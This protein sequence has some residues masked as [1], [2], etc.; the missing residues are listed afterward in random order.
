MTRPRVL[1]FADAAELARAASDRLL[2]KLV[3][4]QADAAVAELCLTGGRIANAVYARLAEVVGESGFDPGQ[5]ELWWGDERFVSSTS[6][7]RNSL[8]ALSLLA[9]SF[10]LDPARTHL[11]PAAEG[12]ADAQQGAHTYATELG[13]TI[14][15]VC[16]LGIGPDGHTASI[17]PNHP[18]FEPTT[19]TVIGVTDSPKPPSERISLTLAAINRSR[20]VWVFA[21]GA[22]KADAVA[23][24]L[25]GDET[26]PAAHV[27]GTERTLWFVDSDAA[28][29]LPFHEC[30]L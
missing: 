30:R 3:E 5:L 6:P 17:F 11:M 4:L 24:C 1:R 27:S 2:A 9:G 23:R 8:Q 16:L 12:V 10:P 14:F 21:S 26:L 28:K 25:A 19:S 29:K 15:D 13:D 7:D 20:E 18:S 22:E